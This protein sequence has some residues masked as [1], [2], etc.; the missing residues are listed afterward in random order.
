MQWSDIAPLVAGAAPT[1]GK[2]LG[3]AVG[4]PL[5][6]AI[7]GT[8]GDILAGALGVKATPEEVHTALTD[9]DQTRVV[10]AVQAAE[11]EAVARWQALSE[12]VKAEADLGKT[13]V[14]EIAETIQSELGLGALATG[15]LRD[16]ILLL[17]ATWR[18]IAMFVWVGTWPWQLWYAFYQTTEAG[19]SGALNALSWWNTT[20]A[21]LAGAYSIGRTFEKVKDV[22][23]NVAGGAGTIAGKVVAAIKG[24][25]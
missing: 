16:F 14:H 24:R 7:G 8:A 22:Q 18:P 17:Q 23:A 9:P 12:M 6:A 15:K 21:L 25:R 5:G 13:Q 19:R 4:G 20:P 11:T 2:M 1:L 10:A 3:G